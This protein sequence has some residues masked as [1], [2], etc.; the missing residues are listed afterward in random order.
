ME[1]SFRDTATTVNRST[2]A[3]GDLLAWIDDLPR[4]PATVQKAC[5][6]AKDPKATAND[7]AALIQYDPMMTAKIL[8]ITNSAFYGMSRKISNVK[9]GIVVLGFAAVRS[10]A[11][12]M[13]AMN[14]FRGTD[15]PFFAYRNF[16]LHSAACAIVSVRMAKL[17]RLPKCDDAF[18]AALLHDIGKVALYQFARDQ[19]RMALDAQRPGRRLDAAIEQRVL[20]ISHAQVGKRLTEKWQLPPDLC[21]AIGGH[22][23]IV[24]RGTPSMLAVVCCISDYVCSRNGL[25][26][27]LGIGSAAAPDWAFK[28]AHIP[29][30]AL[31]MMQDNFAAITKE[32][33]ELV[34]AADMQ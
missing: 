10:L 27:V 22:H 32:A 28:L 21:E 3:L 4:F 13:S 14:V 33:T 12:A 1:T 16:W 6:L 26:S 30:E 19:F 24:P 15:C 8:R 17:A 7:L 5:A 29:P 34:G 31:Q 9:D 18:T 23:G 11:V 20:G 2:I 25:G